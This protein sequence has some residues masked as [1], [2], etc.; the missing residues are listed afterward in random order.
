MSALVTDK[1][2]DS[3]GGTR[4][5]EYHVQC[6]LDLPSRVHSRAEP[7]DSELEKAR[8][9]HELATVIDPQKLADF[10]P[11]GVLGRVTHLALGLS[12]MVLPLVIALDMCRPIVDENPTLEGDGRPMAPAGQARRRPCSGEHEAPDGLVRWSARE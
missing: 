3:S 4:R 1:R 7:L 2:G 10:T 6:P 11:N 8:C 12:L 9:T 5:S